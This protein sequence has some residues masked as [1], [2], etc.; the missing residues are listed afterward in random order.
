MRHS[1][2]LLLLLA[3]PACIDT[4]NSPRAWPDLVGGVAMEKPD[5]CQTGRYA[6]LIGQ[7]KSALAQTALP[8]PT[9]IIAPGTAVTMDYAPTRLNVM[10]NA[11]G[12]ITD[13]R[14]G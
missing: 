1:L 5:P 7:P 13:L 4:P 6:H 9:R 14:C 2:G 11:Q 3:L 10:V 8:A 12:T